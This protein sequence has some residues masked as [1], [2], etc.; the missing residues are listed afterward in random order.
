M[1]LKMVEILMRQLQ[2]FYMM[3]LKTKVVKKHLN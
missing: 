2:V 3:L 1:L